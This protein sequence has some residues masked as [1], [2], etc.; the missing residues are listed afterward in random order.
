MSMFHCNIIQ[1][2][3]WYYISIVCLRKILSFSSKRKLKLREAFHLFY[4]KWNFLRKSLMAFIFLQKSSNS[5]VCLGSEWSS[6]VFILFTLNWK[7]M[8]VHNTPFNLTTQ[9]ILHSLRLNLIGHVAQWLATC[10]RKPKPP[11]SRVRL[12][13]MCRELSAVIA[14]IMSRCMCLLQKCSPPSSAVL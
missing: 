11:G 2:C 3:R 1:L 13:P 5:D 8:L 4:C 10:T 6:A 7:L 9:I 12:L 14:R